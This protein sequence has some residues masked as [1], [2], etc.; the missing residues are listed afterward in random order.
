MLKENI[1]LKEFTTMRTG[2]SARYFFCVKSVDEVEEAVLFAKEKGISFFVL[3]GGSNIIVSDEGFSGVVIKMEIKGL[4]FVENSKEEMRVISGAGVEWDFLVEKTVDRNLYGLENLSL[5]PG[6]VGASPVQNIGAY[7]VEVKDTIAWV[8]VL[9]TET[10]KI[11]KIMNKECLFGYRDSF[12]K[13]AK[14]KKCIILKVAFDLKKN[15]EFKIDYKD[16]TE[17]FLDLSEEEGGDIEPS[18][19]MLREAII[20]IR[21]NKLPNIK[22]IGTAGSFFKNPIVSEVKV[23][24]LLKTYPNLKYHFVSDNTFKLSAGWLFDKVGGWKGVRRDGV[25]VY[26][27]QALVLVGCNGTTT[28]K[29]LSL[30]IEMQNNIKEETGIDLEFEVNII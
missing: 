23:Q 15:G 22:Q 29:I 2:G 19:K 28:K 3:G 9:D 17:Y 27:K 8:E 30:A 25:R 16:I 12:F 10:M 13:F 21:T 18:L 24:E 6:T 4:E 14:G 11:K 7:G 26:E 5:I 20:E 1:S